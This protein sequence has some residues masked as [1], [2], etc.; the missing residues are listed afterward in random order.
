[1]SHYSGARKSGEIERGNLGNQSL[2]PVSGHSQSIV[3]VGGCV[4]GPLLVIAVGWVCLLS[5]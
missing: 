2:N 3:M 5:S 4:L 1:M